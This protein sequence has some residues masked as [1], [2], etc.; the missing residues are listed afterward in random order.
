MCNP[1]YPRGSEWRKWDLQVHTP[2]SSLNNSFS[3]DF[4][5][6]AKTLLESAIEKK[7]A[8]IGV[9]DYFSIEGYKRLK[10]LLNDEARLNSLI[11]TEAAVKAREIL[12]LPNIEFRT[13]VIITRPD[14]HDSRVN[15]HIIFSDEIDP[16][17]IEEHFLRELKFTAESNP[18]AQDERWSLTTINLEN[19]GKRL[20]EQH[21]NFRDQSDIYIGMMNAI[22]A[23][24][25]VT[26]VLERQGSRFKDRFLMIVPADEDLSECSWNGQGHLARK[27]YIQK[28]HMIFS[29]NSGTRA[30]GIG[31]KHPTVQDFINEFRG[32]KPCIHSSDSHTYESLFEPVEARYTWIKAD[33]T[34]HGL[35]QL[36][37]EPEDRVFIGTIPP[38]FERVHSRPTR[39]VEKLEIAKINGSTFAEKWFNCSLCLNPELV[40]IIGNKGSGKSALADILG[41]LG[42]TPRYSSF[43]FL[44]DD[45]FRDSRNNK[46]RHFEATLTWVDRTRE[47][48]ITL[49]SNPDDEAIEKIRYIPQ[50]YLEEICNEVGLGKSS[51]FY[52]ELQQVIFSHVPAAEQLGFDTLDDL[53]EHRSSEINKTISIL[54]AE[55]SDIN[56]QIMTQEDR[57]SPQNRRNLEAQLAERLRELQAHEQTKPTEVSKPD[58]DETIQRIAKEDS[59]AL[60]EKQKLLTEIESDIQI[61]GEKDAQLA[62][63]SAT[64]EKLIR[65]I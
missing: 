9:T 42:N 39:I 61:L 59:Q 19:L 57:L 46:A 20:K 26:E 48:P 36:L 13:S 1:K 35:C 32:L 25:D 56:K 18:G 55:L 22:V 17:I 11:G 40:A 51:R 54:V 2:F 44:R 41:L 5:V 24:E 49:D 43:S 45:R 64:A 38:S 12:L 23:H 10:A 29:S 37:N 3:E 50:N 6:Y 21:E 52:S 4:D 28:S 33:T 31:K 63:K 30:F 60:E 65:E 58:I 62:R 7:I 16:S 14:C 27:L 15:F 8:A 34:F 53:L 47:G